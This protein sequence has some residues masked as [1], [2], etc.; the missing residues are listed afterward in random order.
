MQPK[1]KVGDK[2]KVI[3]GMMAGMTGKVFSEPYL[4]SNVFHYNIVLVVLESESHIFPTLFFEYEL[5]NKDEIP[6]N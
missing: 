1:F 5:E 2:V 6:T 3:N 4:I